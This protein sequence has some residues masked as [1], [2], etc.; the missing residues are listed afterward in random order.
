MCIRDRIKAVDALPDDPALHAAMF[1]YQSD[2]SISDNIGVAFDVTWGD[3][4]VVFVSLDHAVHFH[5]DFRMDE[6]LFVDQSPVIT[7]RSR[8]LARAHVWNTS[9]ELVASITQEALLRMPD[10]AR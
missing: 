8:G 3:P 2:E 1:A 10:S 9:G 6:W 5:R 4:D 7:A